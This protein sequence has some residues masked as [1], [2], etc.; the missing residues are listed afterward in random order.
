MKSRTASGI[1]I[2]FPGVEFAGQSA[3]ITPSSAG[4]AEWWAGT[5]GQVSAT[6]LKHF[7]VD[8]DFDQMIIT[9]IEP[10]AFRDAGAG[11]RSP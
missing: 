1:T 2:S 5:E 8:I 4:F 11:S 10:R 3:I 7:V 9:L 6:F